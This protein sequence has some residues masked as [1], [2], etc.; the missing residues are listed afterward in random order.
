M[1][2]SIPLFRILSMALLAGVLLFFSVQLYQYFSDPLT[3][4]PVYAARTEE[5]ITADGWII[6]DEE[7][8]HAE[9]SLIHY[10]SE[11]ERV[12][13]GQILATAYSSSGALESE[14]SSLGMPISTETVTSFTVDVAVTPAKQKRTTNASARNAAILERVIPTP[15]FL[16]R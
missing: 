1:K 4:T 5:T 6:R 3:I 16:K 11:G 7:V 15:L 13:V 12:G 14:N 2:Q 8:F 9:G 10:F